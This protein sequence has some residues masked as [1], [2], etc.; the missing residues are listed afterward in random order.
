MYHK[1][2]NKRSASRKRSD[3]IEEAAKLP[4]AFI[5]DKSFQDGIDELRAKRNRS[6]K[7]NKLNVDKISTYDAERGPIILHS[8][9]TEQEPSADL[10]SEN[11]LNFHPDELSSLEE[12]LNADETASELGMQ[13]L[14]FKESGGKKK[15]KNKSSKKNK[16]SKTKKSRKSRK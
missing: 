13:G 12:K 15:R 8:F 16:K 5:T 1:F 10:L 9:D 3:S 7:K 6:V 2:T 11:E 14:K 4:H